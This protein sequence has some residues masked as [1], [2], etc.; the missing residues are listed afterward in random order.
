MFY[1]VL[2]L[3]D[4][5]W[6][7]WGSWGSCS[8]TCASGTQSKSRSCSNPAPAHGGA[9]CGGSATSIKGCTRSPC[10]GM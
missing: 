9:S 4:G 2:C 10:P 3:V 5:N 8:V 7:N 6:G 1:F